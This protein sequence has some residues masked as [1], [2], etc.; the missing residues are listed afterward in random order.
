MI[1]AIIFDVDGVLFD[2]FEA[3]FKFYEDLF[4]KAG[5][6]PPTRKEYPKLFH[7]PMMDVIKKIC[8]N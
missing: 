6:I 1:K 7:L 3:N 8:K 5:Y 4:N 2:S